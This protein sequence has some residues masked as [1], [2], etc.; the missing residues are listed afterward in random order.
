VCRLLGM[1][2]ALQL[3]V[4]CDVSGGNV[5]DG[6]DSD[7]NDSDGNAADGGSFSNALGRVPLGTWKDTELLRYM[8]IEPS[9]QSAQQFRVTLFTQQ[10]SSAKRHVSASMKDGILLLNTAEADIPVL[11]HPSG[12]L[13][14]INGQSTFRRVTLNDAQIPIRDHHSGMERSGVY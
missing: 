6:N 12:D 2:V 7:G 10:G 14:L 3:I 4:G 5:S 11:Y 9:G 13:I 8:V 1:F